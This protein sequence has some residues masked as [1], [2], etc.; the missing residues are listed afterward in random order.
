ML[1]REFIIEEELNQQNL[2]LKEE[3]TGETRQS[4]TQMTGHTVD[5]QILLETSKQIY[6][7]LQVVLEFM[8]KGVKGLLVGDMSPALLVEIQKSIGKYEHKCKKVS[9]K[10]TSLLDKNQTLEHFLTT[11]F[12]IGDLPSSG[13]DES[14]ANVY[15]RNMPQ[16]TNMMNNF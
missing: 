12:Q 16:Y 4:V 13:S 8:D 9:A 10:I 15:Q 14:S 11:H 6:H 7:A 5:Q 1:E 3:G 2:S